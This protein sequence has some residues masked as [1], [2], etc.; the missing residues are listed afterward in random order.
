MLDRMNAIYY[1][2]YVSMTDNALK[3]PM[4]ILR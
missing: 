3:R 1:R 4:Q 2:G